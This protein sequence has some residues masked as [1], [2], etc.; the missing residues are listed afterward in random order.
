MPRSR[1]SQIGFGSLGWVVSGA[2]GV[3]AFFVPGQ[4]P[5]NSWDKH[6]DTANRSFENLDYMFVGHGTNDGLRQGSKVSQVVAPN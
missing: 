2:G 3:P 4:A 5:V 6:F 1:Y